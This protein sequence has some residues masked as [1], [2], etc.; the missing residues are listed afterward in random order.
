MLSLSLV[1][2]SFIFLEQVSVTATIA[3]NGIAL[4][5]RYDGGL[6]RKSILG[7]QFVT[8]KIAKAQSVHWTVSNSSLIPDISNALGS[9][10]LA[11]KFN[12][13]RIADNYAIEQL[14]LHN[15]LSEADLAVIAETGKMTMIAA[16]CLGPL[17]SCWKVAK[18]KGIQFLFPDKPFF[19]F[20]IVRWGITILEVTAKRYQGH[21]TFTFLHDFHPLQTTKFAGWWGYFAKS[22]N[23]RA[24][25]RW[26]HPAVR[27]AS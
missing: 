20:F 19:Q 2:F 23:P 22:K 13:F 4:A 6:V 15:H 11:D 12:L 1:M 27:S 25:L 7:Q 21:A 5:E 24:V 16:E 9:L 14:I 17:K 26:R 8:M 10:I 3:C 18:I